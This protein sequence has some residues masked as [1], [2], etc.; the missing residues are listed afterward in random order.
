MASDLQYSDVEAWLEPYRH[1]FHNV[2]QIPDENVDFNVEITCDDEV[3]NVTKPPQRDLLVVGC[4]HQFGDEFLG[5]F[6][7]RSDYEKLTFLLQMESILVVLP[8]KFVFCDQHG[9]VSGFSGSF[10]RLRFERP[11]F[12]QG[13]VRQRLVDTIEQFAYARKFVGFNEY[14]YLSELNP[15][16]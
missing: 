15:Q 6:I 14:V 16:R 5:N 9:Q 4:T 1:R 8:G 13:A 2:R 7:N 3:V 11:V 10:Q 12:P